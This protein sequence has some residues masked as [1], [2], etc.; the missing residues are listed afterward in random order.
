MRKVE[1]DEI[2]LKR[3]AVDRIKELKRK[4]NMRSGLGKLFKMYEGKSY[5]LLPTL[6]NII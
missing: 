1:D 4:L 2:D 6:E 5:I 3:L